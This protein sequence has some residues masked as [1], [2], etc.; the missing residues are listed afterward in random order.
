MLPD[1]QYGFMQ[2]SP[3]FPDLN[4]GALIT[5]SIKNLGLEGYRN[6]MHLKERQK[7][8]KNMDVLNIVQEVA[9]TTRGNVQNK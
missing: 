8:P 2:W 1:L 4:I 6:V 3:N 7:H 5:K 9:H